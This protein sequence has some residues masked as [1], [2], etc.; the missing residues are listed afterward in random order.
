[1][2]PESIPAGQ[3]GNDVLPILHLDRDLVV[4]VKPAGLLV[5]R[6]LIDRH[7]TRF[8]LQLLRDQLG[9]RVYP[10][11]RL[12]K[13]TSGVM[14]LALTRD[15]ARTLGE[16]FSAGQVK[17]EYLAIC[18]GFTQTAERIDYPLKEEADPLSDAQADPHKPAQTAL[19]DYQRWARMELPI[20]IGRYPS[21][22]YSLVHLQPH[23]G[24][25]HQLRRHMKH[26]FHPIIGD[27]SHGDGR[28]NRGFRDYCGVGEL[29]LCGWR[30]SFSH[31]VSGTP[32]QFT[33]P[34]SH[35]WRQ[36][37]LLPQWQ[38][39]PAAPAW[40]VLLNQCTVPAVS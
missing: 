31:P 19:T 24:R 4:V 36:A 6:S 10:V 28:Q 9:Q 17:K 27:T 5:H 11:H 32:M 18:R 3:T 35:A 26:I 37:L 40:S 25:K 23:T 30:L 29:M 21:A 34:L 15:V 14:V 22:R 12:D 7:E 13:P 1:M 38:A 16:Q 8:L 33:A 2:C 20:A 39:D